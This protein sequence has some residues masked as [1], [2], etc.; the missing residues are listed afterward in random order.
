MHVCALY[1]RV[2]CTCGRCYR[3]YTGFDLASSR[4]L[5]SSRTIHVICSCSYCCAHAFRELRFRGNRERRECLMIA[6]AAVCDKILVRQ[7]DDSRSRLLR[8]DL[9]APAAAKR[10]CRAI[11]LVVRARREARERDSSKRDTTSTS[12]RRSFQ[13]Q[14][15]HRSP[16]VIRAPATRTTNFSR[17]SK[18]ALC[19]TPFFRRTKIVCMRA[20]IYAAIV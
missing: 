16:I 18:S 6:V 9:I 3:R 12:L 5:D 1:M 7:L 4:M 15:I 11:S 19:L 14:T 13:R 17:I 8:Q 20:S 10:W 2:H